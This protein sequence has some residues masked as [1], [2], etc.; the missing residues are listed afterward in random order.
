MK[1]PKRATTSKGS[2][3]EGLGRKKVSMVMRPE[4]HHRLKIAA[5]I[6]QREMSNILEEAL[7]RYLDEQDRK[8]R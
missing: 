6:D 7:T 2:Q 5:A 8:R 4:L 1:K 3:K